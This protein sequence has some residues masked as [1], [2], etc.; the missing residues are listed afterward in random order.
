MKQLPDGWQTLLPSWPILSI[1]SISFSS[2]IAQNR[3]PLALNACHSYVM[4]AILAPQSQGGNTSPCD[5]GARIAS[6]FFPVV[7]I[8]PHRLKYGKLHHSDTS[9]PLP[10]EQRCHPR[11][12]DSPPLPTTP[13][14]TPC[15]CVRRRG[16]YHA[17][18]SARSHKKIYYFL[19]RCARANT[20]P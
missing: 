19:H 15:A 12:Q 18:A 7:K 20:Q 9:R 10:K 14:N 1:L 17:C 4:L 8:T 5:C 16:V 3:P 2:I 11:Q 13:P 6:L